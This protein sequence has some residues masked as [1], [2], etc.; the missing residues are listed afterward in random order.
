MCIRDRG[1]GAQVVA[2]E[3]IAAAPGM[4]LRAVLLIFLQLILYLGHFG[5]WMNMSLVAAMGLLLLGWQALT[6]P[7]LRQHFVVMFASVLLAQLVTVLLFYSAYTGPVSYTHLDV[8]KRQP[9]PRSSSPT[10]LFT[11]CMVGTAQAGRSIPGA[12]AVMSY[13][14]VGNAWTLPTL[15]S[16]VL[17]LPR[18][19]SP[20]SPFPIP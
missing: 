20:T 12:H 19:Y 16:R 10:L 15:V 17:C 7:G 6:K 2:Q 9:L 18:S 4:W 14:L 3:H 11:R 13:R 5:F 1:A 8:Y